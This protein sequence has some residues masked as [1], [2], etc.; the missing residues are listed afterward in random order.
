M[1]A[2]GAC[3]KMR[4][5]PGYYQS[6]LRDFPEKSSH[7]INPIDL[8]IKR[9]WPRVDGITGA[10]TPGWDRATTE[11]SNLESSRNILLAYSRRN[12]Y[13]G[14]CQGMNFIVSDILLHGIG[15][16]VKGEYQIFY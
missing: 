1:I 5:N 6:L 10:N 3:Q 12:P 8:D 2:S 15:E 14:Y 9:T 11:A 7:F 13:I 16:E 4:E